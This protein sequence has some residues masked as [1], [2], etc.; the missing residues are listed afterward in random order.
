[1]CSYNLQASR[2]DAV[3]AAKLVVLQF[4][5]L[6]SCKDYV[7]FKLDLHKQRKTLMIICFT[8]RFLTFKPYCCKF[9]KLWKDNF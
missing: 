1:M 7:P 5:Q 3:N 6:S 2:K 4:N 9:V 8:E